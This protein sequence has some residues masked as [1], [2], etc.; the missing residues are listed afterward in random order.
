MSKTAI[1][2][3]LSLSV[4][5]L[6]ALASAT[7]ATPAP[8]KVV[9]IGDPITL[10]WTSAFAANPNWIN[11]GAP[12]SGGYSNEMLARFQSDVVSLHP[13]IVHIMAGGE[14]SYFVS[15]ESAL[16]MSQSLFMNL[17]A[18]VKAAKAANIKVILGTTPPISNDSGY[19]T[20]VN[21]I[22][23]GYGAANNIPVVD[24]AD[25]I[26]GCASL[27]MNYNAPFLTSPF[28]TT[29]TGI[30]P[31]PATGY[32]PSTAG[33][34]AMTQLAEVAVATLNLKLV[35]GWLSNTSFGEG[36]GGQANINTLSPPDYVQFTPIGLY[37][38]GSQHPMI[39]SNMQDATGTWTSSNPVVMNV[40]QQGLAWALSN[41]TTIIRYTAPNGVAF[42]EWIM[43]VNA[44]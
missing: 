15:D 30:L 10:N 33:Y 31:L 44:P 25:A 18:M 7:A 40:N 24:Y 21:A 39:N 26:C 4:L 20:Q 41:G 43:Y 5:V 36:Y 38:D 35:G 14:D 3:F 23:A 34:A 17:D 16:Y 2:S 11:K 19:I 28:M 37:S 12:F 13:A 6:S 27:G 9:F 29:A 42:S 22:I 32:L 1:R 8:P